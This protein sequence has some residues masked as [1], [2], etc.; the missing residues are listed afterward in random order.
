MD[1]FGSASA[2]FVMFAKGSVGQR[3]DGLCQTRR[4]GRLVLAHGTQMREF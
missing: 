4:H 2:E 3:S 1:N